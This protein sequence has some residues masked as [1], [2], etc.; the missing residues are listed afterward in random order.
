MKQSALLFSVGAAMLATVYAFTPGT[1]EQLRIQ[2]LQSTSSDNNCLDDKG[3]GV[4]PPNVVTDRRSVLFTS[5]MA[6]VAAT[7]NALPAFADEV[8]LQQYA[9]FTKAPEGWSYRDVN[10]GK[11]DSPSEGDRAVFEWSG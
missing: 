8:N 1:Q 6:V 3:N 10:V 2:A 4:V 11:G 9:D 7:T 5:G